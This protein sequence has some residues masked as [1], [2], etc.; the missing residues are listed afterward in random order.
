MHCS[1]DLL[2]Q[3]D[4]SIVIMTDKASAS[5]TEPQIDVEAQ[6]ARIR[7]LCSKGQ[8]DCGSFVLLQ[9]LLECP[10][11]EAGYIGSPVLLS[12]LRFL[13]F[14]MST[15]PFHHDHDYPSVIEVSVYGT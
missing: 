7:R 14:R 12:T 15:L 6:N 10:S 1:L 4:T 9:A 2:L 3:A 5:L 8:G 11:L 13:F